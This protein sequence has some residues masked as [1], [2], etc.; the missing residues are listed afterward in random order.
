VQRILH[1]HAGTIWAE[2][3]LDKGACFYFTLGAAPATR[4][5]MSEQIA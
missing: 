5:T 1:K 4:P 3:E 2:A